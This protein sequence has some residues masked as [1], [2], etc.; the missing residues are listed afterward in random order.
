MVPTLL[1]VKVCL[2]TSLPSPCPALLWLTLLLPPWIVLAQGLCTG[3]SAWNTLPHVP[4]DI[5]SLLLYGLA[6]ISHSRPPDLNL[7][8]LQLATFLTKSTPSPTSLI[9]GTFHF[10]A[11]YLL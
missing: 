9:P 2:A 8:F 1:R 10:L 3:L 4:P 7:I 5:L 6:Q 11:N